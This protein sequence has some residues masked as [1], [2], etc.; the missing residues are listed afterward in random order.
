MPAFL[1]S[2][3]TVFDTKKFALSE[4]V[5]RETEKSVPISKFRNYFFKYE[6]VY[7]NNN[8]SRG[9]SSHKDNKTVEIFN[10]LEKTCQVLIYTPSQ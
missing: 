4:I 5:K 7:N 3:I 9:G 6:R 8:T 10:D 2:S 1:C